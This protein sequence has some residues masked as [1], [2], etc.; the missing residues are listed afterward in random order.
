MPKLQTKSSLPLAL[1]IPAFVTALLCLGLGSLYFSAG[2]HGLTLFAWYLTQPLMLTLNLLPFL[3]LGLLLLALTGRAWLAF[4]L[5]AV[6][7]LHASGRYLLD[8][9]LTD[10]LPADRAEL[11]AQMERIQYYLTQDAG[12]VHP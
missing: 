4:G 1:T 3:L 10:T 8:G 7:M 12:G 6:P 5:D 2:S 9:S 11:A